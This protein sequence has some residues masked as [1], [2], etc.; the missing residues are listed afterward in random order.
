M[1]DDAVYNRLMETAEGQ[2]SNMLGSLLRKYLVEYDEGMEKEGY[3]Q[4]GFGTRPNLPGYQKRTD[5]LQ[6]RLM[7]GSATKFVSEFFIRNGGRV[8]LG[9]LM[10]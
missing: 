1:Y 4:A 6:T 10:I 9:G 5:E 7:D 3:W 8:K 2:N